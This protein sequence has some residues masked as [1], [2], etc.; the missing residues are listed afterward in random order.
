MNIGF[1]GMNVTGSLVMT[2]KPK[3]H[4]TYDSIISLLNVAES[5]FAK[6]GATPLFLPISRWKGYGGASNVAADSI[7]S[8]SLASAIL[9][10]TKKT[11]VFASCATFAYAPEMLGHVS[12]RLNFEYQ[13]RFGLNLIGGWKKDEFEYFNKK[14]FGS[15]SEIYEQAAIWLSRFRHSE[16][17]HAETL[18]QILLNKNTFSPCPLLC[19]AFSPEGRTFARNSNASLFTTIRKIDQAEFGQY[20]GNSCAFSL[21]VRRSIDQS[22]AYYEELLG[23][24]NCDL[25]AANN[26][27]DQLADSNPA[28]SLLNRMNIKLVKSGAG[29]EEL[30]CDP[31]GLS[32]FLRQARYSGIANLFFSLPD[33]DE[34]F[35]IL[36][37]VFSRQDWI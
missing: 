7:E 6:Q 30:V 3:W 8:V 10:S 32:D 5:C 20:Q 18:N 25:D 33:Y 13:N 29:I 9:S 2:K 24:V 37:D 35:D 28:K 36:L 1:F 27:C 31:Q 12:A 26:F 4:P 19:A 14:F 15:S 11:K 16:M 17:S 23:D 34:S 21:F 22:K